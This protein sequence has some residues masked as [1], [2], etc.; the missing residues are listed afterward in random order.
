MPTRREQ[1]GEDQAVAGIDPNP[2]VIHEM[3]IRPYLVLHADLPFF[4]DPDCTR[5]VKDARLVV[6]RSEDPR[7]EHHPVECMPTRKRYE[8]GQ[9]LR[10]EINHKKQWGDSWYVNPATGLKEK[11]W[12]RA[13]ELIAPRF[14]G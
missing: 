10:W 13:V 6:I 14:A 12:A 11:A 4:S 2:E 1:Q 5:E 3:P 8:V 9:I 7:Q